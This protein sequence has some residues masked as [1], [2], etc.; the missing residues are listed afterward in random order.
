MSCRN[1][2]LK[3]PGKYTNIDCSLINPTNI[4]HIFINT[5]N[6]THL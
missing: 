2:R 1:E 5:T 3:E 6:I 4:T